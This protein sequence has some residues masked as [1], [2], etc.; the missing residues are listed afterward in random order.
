MTLNK[1]MVIGNV[2]R[3]P[4]MRFTPGGQAVTTFSVA[5]SRRWRGQD[6]EQKEHTE[7]FNVV[8]WGRLA[9]RC[10]QWITKGSKVYI[11]GR[12]E[13]RSWDGQ[14]GQ[15]HYR[16]EVIASDMRLLDS[17]QQV[18]GSGT[19]PEPDA[20]ADEFEPDDIPF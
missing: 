3:D 13:T 4:E 7:W 12:L 5:S 17:R 1:V 11:E 9:E 18:A 14:D 2:G 6:N 20:T 10:N 19:R 16:T 8:A 15:K